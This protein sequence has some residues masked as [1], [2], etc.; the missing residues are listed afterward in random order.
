MEY[1]RQKE[2]SALMA[3]VATVGVAVATAVLQYYELSHDTASWFTAAYAAAAVGAAVAAVASIFASRQLIRKRQ[4]SRIFI[5][6][7][8]ED[9]DVARKIA[10]FVEHAGFEPWLDMDQVLPGEV[11]R[12]TVFRALERSAAAVLLVSGHSVRGSSFV[13]KELVS[14]LQTLQEPEPGISPVIPIRLDDTPVPAPLDGVQW[15]D[16]R[17]EGAFERLALGLDR[18]AAAHRTGRATIS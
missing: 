3:G 13:G 12:D 1:Q 5:I 8:R 11:W 6:Y 10:S 7:A 2:L 15:V 14:A 18:V 16:I 17:E 4:P 9:L